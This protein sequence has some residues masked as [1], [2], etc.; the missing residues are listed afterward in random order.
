MA[1]QV[2]MDLR[3][4][5]LVTGRILDAALANLAGP[6]AFTTSCDEIIDH[7]DA[8]LCNTVREIVV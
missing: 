7:L 5:P 8:L 2:R 6:G 4:L 1:V 3:F